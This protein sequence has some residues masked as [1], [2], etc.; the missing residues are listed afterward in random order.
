M[1]V[2]DGDE[3]HGI[4][5]LKKTPREKQTHPWMGHFRQDGQS[6]KKHTMRPLRNDDLKLGFSRGVFVKI[7]S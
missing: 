4:E 7:C 2:K 6:L 5:S 1:V 3:S